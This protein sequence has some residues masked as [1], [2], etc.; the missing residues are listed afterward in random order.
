MSIQKFVTTFLVITTM[1]MSSTEAMSPSPSGWNPFPKK[2]VTVHNKLTS[3][4][5]LQFHCK[6]KN[7]D[8]GTHT[9]KNNY[10][11]RF[12]FNNNPWGTTQF[13]CSFQWGEGVHWFDIYI[14]GRDSGRCIEC[15]W[16]IMESGPCLI[17]DNWRSCYNWNK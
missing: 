10:R 4:D 12:S 5:W 17:K 7:D 3:H 8:L 14:E 2:K 16:D 6:S 1:I 9:L 11:Y 15:N 13:Y